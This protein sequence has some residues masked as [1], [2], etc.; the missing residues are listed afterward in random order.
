MA[1]DVAREAQRLEVQASQDLRERAGVQPHP[2]QGEL[3][4]QMLQHLAY[5]EK[6]DPDKL[7]ATLNYVANDTKGMAAL[8]I[9]ATLEKDAN[10]GITSIKFN[11]DQNAPRNL[12][13][14]QNAAYAQSEFN[15]ILP[16]ASDQRQAEKLAQAVAGPRP[17]ALQA[18]VQNLVDQCVPSLK[19]D[20]LLHSLPMQA[21]G[22]QVFGMMQGNAWRDQ[23]YTHTTKHP[24]KMVAGVDLS[25]QGI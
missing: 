5:L 15:G 3:H 20:V 14:E 12:L 2:H 17:G 22:A 11:Y 8:G 23:I 13:P 25:L 1:N 4:E 18:E 9:A 21:N 7:Q 24:T 6:T 19:V 10:G 16:N